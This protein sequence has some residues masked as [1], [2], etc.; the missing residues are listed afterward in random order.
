M[1]SSELSKYF[2]LFHSSAGHTVA[3]KP[4]HTN[5]DDIHN[6]PDCA[7]KTY[8]IQLTCIHEKSRSNLGWDANCPEICR[9]FLDTSRN[10]LGLY[11]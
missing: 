2:C 1:S 11:L 9:V 4:Y 6:F 7:N 8:L 3:N 10:I 5:T